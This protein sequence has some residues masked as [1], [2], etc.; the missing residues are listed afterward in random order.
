M[1]KHLGEGGKSG[2]GCTL[3]GMKSRKT[4]FGDKSMHHKA[5]SVNGG[6]RNKV[7]ENRSI[8]SGRVDT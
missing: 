3:K 1:K 6:T 7:G 5:G 4:H 8:K 2:A